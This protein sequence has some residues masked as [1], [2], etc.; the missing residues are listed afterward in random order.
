MGCGSS[1]PVTTFKKPDENLNTKQ[2][3]NDAGYIKHKERRKESVSS[4]SSKTKDKSSKSSSRS[5]S[6]STLRDRGDSAKSDRVKSGKSKKIDGVEPDRIKSGQSG[7]LGSGVSD[8]V[9]SGKSDRI[10]SGR[11]DRYKTDQEYSGTEKDVQNEVLDSKHTE[12]NEVRE[13]EYE[14]VDKETEETYV[15]VSNTGV[16]SET[17]KSEK[18]KD[19]PEEH[20]ERDEYEHLDLNPILIPEMNPN[21][22]MENYTIDDVVNNNTAKGKNNWFLYGRKVYSLDLFVPIVFNRVGQYLELTN[23]EYLSADN[24]LSGHS[25]YPVYVARYYGVRRKEMNAILPACQIGILINMSRE[26]FLSRLKHCVDNIKTDLEKE[27][28][29]TE[30]LVDYLEQL[31][32]W[33]SS[34]PNVELEPPV[35]RT[36]VDPNQCE[37][38]LPEKIRADS[39]VLR[40]WSKDWEP[41]DMTIDEE[42]AWHIIPLLNEDWGDVHQLYA[43]LVAGNRDEAIPDL[44]MEI[45]G[46]AAWN[47]IELDIIKNDK[48]TEGQ[49][50]IWK[51]RESRKDLDDPERMKRRRKQLA[52]NFLARHENSKRLKAEDMI[53]HLDWASTLEQHWKE[54][55]ELCENYVHRQQVSQDTEKVPDTTD[56]EPKTL[57]ENIPPQD[58]LSLLSDHGVN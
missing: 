1:T 43:D 8:R 2:I 26:E 22:H 56:L 10:G 27:E 36:N 44:D 3:A 25:G 54:F 51:T 38:P 6:S 11:S 53:P 45:E 9:R 40:Y 52:D 18:E 34:Y 17:N 19:L 33:L 49:E 35:D 55:Q 23:Q 13:N 41:F 28:H 50:Q 42:G 32:R 31:S 14:F 58:T 12:D 29:L 24:M 37:F 30:N 47:V 57:P 46:E 5:S 21:K 7:R 20:E 4:K 16:V 15:F 39:T 48:T